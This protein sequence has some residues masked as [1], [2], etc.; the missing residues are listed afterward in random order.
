MANRSINKVILVGNLGADPETRYTASGVPVCNIRVATSE[1]WTDKDSGEQQE[2]TE[3][4][5]VIMWRGLAEVAS[6]YLEKGDRVY[7]EGKI[8][9]RKYQDANGQDRI[10][11]EIVCDEMVMLGGRQ[12]EQRQDQGDYRRA[13]QPREST[14]QQ[15]QPSHQGRDRYPEAR[16]PQRPSAQQQ[17]SRKQE[18]FNDDIP[19]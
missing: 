10:T 3:W 1:S 5:R 2:R 8:Q 12:P 4:H 16:P 11:T 18:D 19:F 6:Q 17:N 7:I 13:A 9:S 14:R 15:Q